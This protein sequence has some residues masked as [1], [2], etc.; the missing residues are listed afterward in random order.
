MY[1]MSHRVLEDN[2]FEHVNM[3]A[4][5]RPVGAVRNHLLHTVPTIVFVVFVRSF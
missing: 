4:V 2:V 3:K 1:G 5:E